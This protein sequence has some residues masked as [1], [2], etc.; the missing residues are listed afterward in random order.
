MSNG[1]WYAVWSDNRL[2]IV[3]QHVATKSRTYKCQVYINIL[4]H[5]SIMSSVLRIDAVSFYNPTSCK[6]TEHDAVVRSREMHSVDYC[7]Y[8][9]V[10]RW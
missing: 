1:S 10:A 5:R 6:I 9:R 7:A 2:G 3:C 8:I 4:H